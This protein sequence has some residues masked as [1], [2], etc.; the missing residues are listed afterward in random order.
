MY[1]YDSAPGWLPTH[2][3]TNSN[4]VQ[5]HRTRPVR[6]HVIRVTRCEVSRYFCTPNNRLH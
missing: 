2:T 4:I 1:D 3:S 5:P 6:V